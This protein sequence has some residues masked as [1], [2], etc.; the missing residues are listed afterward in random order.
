MLTLIILYLY[1]YQYVIPTVF[2]THNTEGLCV[3]NNTKWHDIKRERGFQWVNQKS[4]MSTDNTGQN[5]KK[6]IQKDK[7]PLQNIRQRN[8]K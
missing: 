7:L 4:F 8:E 6:N 5:L 1:K 3:L 2:Q